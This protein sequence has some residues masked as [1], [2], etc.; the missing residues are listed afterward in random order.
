MPELARATEVAWV[1]KAHGCLEDVPWPLSAALLLLGI[2]G[3]TG[4][5]SGRNGLAHE[6]MADFVGLKAQDSLHCIRG[7]D[8]TCLGS[9]QH[10][11]IFPALLN[12][13]MGQ[14]TCSSIV[15]SRSVWTVT[16]STVLT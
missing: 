6:Q 1:L 16:C 12:F 5:T 7:A 13:K 3:N 11:R 14:A 2:T 8:A 9:P 10:C 4:G 15:S